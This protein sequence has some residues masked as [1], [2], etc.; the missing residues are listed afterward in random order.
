MEFIIIS[1][2]KIVLVVLVVF[3]TVANLVW[4]ERRTSAFIQDRLGPNRVGPWGLFQS[5]A[6]VIKLF[7]KEDIIPS[8]VDRILC[9]HTRADNLHRRCTDHVFRYPV[10][11]FHQSLWP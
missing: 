2:I 4:V 1:L 3:T 11:Q 7:F 5:P 8:H 9:P 6:D 10:R